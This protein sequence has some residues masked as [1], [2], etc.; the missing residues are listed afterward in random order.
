MELKRAVRKLVKDSRDV[1]SI[2]ASLLH[3]GFPS[4]IKQAHVAKLKKEV[5]RQQTIIVGAINPLLS[6]MQER[7][8]D[9]CPYCNNQM[10]IINIAGDSISKALF[11]KEDRL[12][13]PIER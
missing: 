2:T 6:N 12:V 5:K 10:E 11:C 1:D 13:I 8:A 3:A 7:P 4:R 9:M